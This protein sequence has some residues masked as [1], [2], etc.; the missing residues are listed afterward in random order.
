[1]THL[2]TLKLRAQL[3]LIQ[4]EH[5]LKGLCEVE[6]EDLKQSIRSE[7][8]GQ[9]DKAGKLLCELAQ[10]EK[11]QQLMDQAMLE[12]MLNDPGYGLPERYCTLGGYRA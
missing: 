7:I 9:L 3:H 8:E 5:M 6:G 4:A 12:A 1:M 11:L 10:W 2:K